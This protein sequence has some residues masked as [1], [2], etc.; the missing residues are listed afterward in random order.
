[1]E[2]GTATTCEIRRN[3]WLLMS[4]RKKNV[5]KTHSAKQ[6]GQTS[7][8]KVGPM[9]VACV[10]DETKPKEDAKE[11]PEEDGRMGKKLYK[12]FFDGTSAAWT[13][14]FTAVLAIFTILL[15]RVA[16]RSDETARTTQRAFLN[17]NG[18]APTL[19]ITDP[20]GA[21]VIAY[22]MSSAWENSGTTPAR[23]GLSRVSFRWFPGT[24]PRDFKFGDIVT[25]ETRTFV[26]GPKGTT[27]IRLIPPVPISVFSGIQTG[28]THLYF[29]GW[30]TYR[31]IF[32]NTN[33]HL[34]EFCAEII[35]IASSIPDIADPKAQFSISSMVCRT[36]NC[37]DEDCPDYKE[38]IR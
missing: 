29:W 23:R 8:Q 12:F 38:R 5:C 6:H 32:P 28:A 37:Y 22:Q 10:A 19:R 34:T 20:S 3:W 9:P 24:M 4:G 11:A 36:H 35:G 18:L 33:T 27:T 30:T 13:A 26:L 16:D 14:V 15:Y 21:K 7:Q 2:A 31:D 17:I 25:D 1:M